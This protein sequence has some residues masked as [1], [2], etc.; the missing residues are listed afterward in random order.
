MNRKS[1][2]REI[3]TVWLSANLV[4]SACSLAQAQQTAV[5]SHPVAAQGVPLKRV[6]ISAPAASKATVV[7]APKSQ[8]STTDSVLAMVQ[9][10][11][12]DD[13]IVTRLRKEDR[14]MDLSTDELISLKKAKVS[15]AVVK[16]MLD[17]RAE[18]TNSIPIAAPSPAPAP[19]LIVQAPM[20]A[21]MPVA[22]SSGATPAS[23]ASS[24]ADLNDP[25]APH[26]SGIYLLTKDRDG[27]PE[28]VVLE[29]AG[30]QGSKTGGFFTSQLTYGIKKIK[31]KAIIPGPRASIRTGDP[32]ATFYFYFDD[33]A[34]GL[35]KSFFGGAVSNPNQFALLR[36][37]VGKSNRETM[38]GAINAFGASTGTDE[39]RMVGFKAERLRAG[40]Y[41]VV[42]N[43]PLEPGEYCFLASA[44]AYGTN[45]AGAAGAVD[46]FDFAVTPKD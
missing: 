12:S 43:V 44:G 2:V 37:E 17:P 35:G 9:A 14:P 25:S 26:D 15:D 3:F 33:K 38:I 30:Y 41:K 32:S 23:G 7:T 28:M 31:T 18:I 21:G 29:R 1:V 36:L 46:I 11:I 39:K 6:V 40:L 27:K 5:P 22:N 13:L 45:A 34:A 19:P 10:G 20:L 8:G 42:P 24:A 4:L 16:M